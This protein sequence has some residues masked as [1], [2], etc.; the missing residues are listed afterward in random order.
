MM[1][2][3]RGSA[4]GNQVGLARARAITSMSLDGR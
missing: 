1:Y 2:S 4:S 3:T